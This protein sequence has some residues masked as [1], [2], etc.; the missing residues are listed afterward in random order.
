MSK[1]IEIQD[2][3]KRYKEFELQVSFAIEEGQTLALVGPNGSGKTTMICT[4]LNV[5]RRDRGE[6]R[7]FGQ[8]L[9]AHESEIKRRLGVFFEEPRLFDEFRVKDSLEFFAAFYPSW[10]WE[11]ALRLLSRF[12]ID[13]QKKFKKL[14]K[15]MK[16]KAALVAAF[17]PKPAALILDEP[18]AGL[19]PSMRRLFIETVREAQELFSPTILL[20]S[21]ILKDVEELADRIAFLQNGRIVLLETAEALRRWVVVKGSCVGELPEDLTGGAIRFRSRTVQGKSEFSLLMDKQES[22]WRAQIEACGGEV[23]ASFSPDLDE[24]YSWILHP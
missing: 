20:T 8:E 3:N 16:V 14:S 6:V 11:Y 5:V 2:L 1:A 7:W 24:I 19:D 23:N 17:A 12:G 15:G 4:L 10:D 18:T 9:D 22:V 13:P 21:H